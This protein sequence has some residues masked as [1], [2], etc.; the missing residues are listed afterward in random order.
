L[1]LTGNSTA[2]L[3][4]WVLRVDYDRVVPA[5]QKRTGGAV[6]QVIPEFDPPL[7][8]VPIDIDCEGSVFGRPE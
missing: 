1:A 5:D 7:I 6:S 2:L 3:N 8:L 4:F